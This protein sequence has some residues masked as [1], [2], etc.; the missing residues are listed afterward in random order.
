MYKKF[1]IN[2]SF[3]VFISSFLSC[4]FTHIYSQ[5]N[6]LFP[7][8]N[9]FFKRANNLSTDKRF[10]EV[11]LYVNSLDFCHFNV[12]K[13]RGSELAALFSK[14]D[15]LQLKTVDARDFLEEVRSGVFYELAMEHLVAFR[16][17][18]FY[19][20]KELIVL[21]DFWTKELNKDSFAKNLRAL[22]AEDVDKTELKHRID[23]LSLFKDRIACYVGKVGEVLSHFSNVANSYDEKRHDYRLYEDL[24]LCVKEGVFCINSFFTKK[25]DPDK[26]EYND[27][28]TN[29][30]K[31]DSS[32][33]SKIICKNHLNIKFMDENFIHQINDYKI[34]SFYQQ[35]WL[36]L[37]V[38]GA[39]G[40]VTA[41]A[42]LYNLDDVTEVVK[43]RWEKTTGA[44]GGY[45]SSSKDW[46]IENLWPEY[47]HDYIDQNKDKIRNCRQEFERRFK[48]KYKE[49]TA[50]DKEIFSGLPKSGKDYKRSL[51]QLFDALQK[52]EEGLGD[53]GFQRKMVIENFDKH[54]KEFDRII[55]TTKAKHV[56]ILR[57][58]TNVVTSLKDPIDDIK[59]LVENLII[60]FG[61][62]G[63]CGK[64][65]QLIV[66]KNVA[67]GMKPIEDGL[68]SL[69]ALGNWIRVLLPATIAIVS[70]II[71][72]RKIM[73]NRKQKKYD[74]VS[75]IVS[76]VYSVLNCYNSSNVDYYQPDLTY[77][78]QGLMNFY[79]DC[80]QDCK[81]LVSLEDRNK[82]SRLVT[83]LRNSDL[84]AVQK[85][86]FIKLGWGK[87]LFGVA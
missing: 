16:E 75:G 35:H 14:I 46:V 39:V 59:E 86:D 45:F 36:G 77:K 23:N 18:L 50:K 32:Q 25:F 69:R 30:Y 20:L 44:V 38:W 63:N 73:H 71:I 79:I 70:T 80:L 22:L 5:H 24:S 34:P 7:D 12:K 48:E 15:E 60:Q 85:L 66:Y 1:V 56:G 49:L 54:I 31:L 64:L 81:D 53:L 4:S 72:V 43:N 26:K 29:F 42:I 61:G 83:D 68:L 9:I 67:E 87:H 55:E 8:T 82:L 21:I 76:E 47:K 84:S 2:L 40:V 11:K 13:I 28:L 52:Q 62:L 65:Y 3:I 33:V 58:G 57:E 27:Y 10:E 6:N 74:K 78:D 37:Y 51:E 41:G 19:S 17:S